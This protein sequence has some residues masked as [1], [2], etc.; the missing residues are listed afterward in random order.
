MSFNSNMIKLVSLLGLSALTSAQVFSG[1]GKVVPAV[2]TS[3]GTIGEA[4][5]CLTDAGLWTT[6]SANCGTY[7]G[8][9]T[10]ESGTVVST[11]L[12]TSAGY[13]NIIFG[14]DIH[15]HLSYACGNPDAN[16]ATATEVLSFASEPFLGFGEY[17]DLGVTGSNLLPEMIH[18]ASILQ[19]TRR[20]A[21]CGC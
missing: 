13:C 21:T 2:W 14:G 9:A 6:D 5:G 12:S 8:V 3:R 16:T 19:E 17:W 20:L 15:D 4:I 11:I 18:P 7:T 10:T 1:Q